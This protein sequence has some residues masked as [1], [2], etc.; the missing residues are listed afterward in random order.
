MKFE[1]TLENFRDEVN[2]DIAAILAEDENAF[3]SFL[4][5]GMRYSLENGGKRLRP[6]MLKSAYRAF[7]GDEKFEIFAVRYFA[8]AMECIHSYSLVH[9]DLPEMDNDM[10]RRGKLTTHARFGQAAAVLAGDALLNYA[11]ELCSRMICKTGLEYGDNK[12]MLS[13]AKAMNILAGK[14]GAG[15]MIGG[16]SVDVKLTGEKLDDRQL[17][18]INKNKTSALISAALMCG[19]AL[20]GADEETLS[21]LEKTGESVGEAFQIRD[22]IL[23]EI[24][25][26]EVLGKPI[27]SDA[28]NNKTTYVTIHGLEKAQEKVKEDMDTAFANLSCLFGRYGKENDKAKENREFLLELFK[29]LVEREK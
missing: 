3:E 19:A 4:F 5:E 11:F 9:D 17:D 20:A 23:D 25:T 29:S 8:V 24:S 21:I 14:A 13:A 10:Y 1:E 27:H 7:G 12:K 26:E 15:G 22:D 6:I 16:Q 28:E 2:N 18:Y